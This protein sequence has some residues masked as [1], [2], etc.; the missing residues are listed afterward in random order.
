MTVKVRIKFFTERGDFLS[1]TITMNKDEYQFFA[2][3]MMA[4]DTDEVMPLLVKRDGNP[5]VI[6]PRYIIACEIMG[7]VPDTW[8]DGLTRSE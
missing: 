7:F 1:D 2:K 5:L 8:M 6:N 4:I 3:N